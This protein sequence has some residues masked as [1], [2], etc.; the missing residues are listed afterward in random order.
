MRLTACL[1]TFNEERYIDICLDSIYPYV[2]EIIC[3]D[4]GSTDNTVNILKKYPKVRCYVVPQPSERRSYTGWNEGDR[5]NIT[6]DLARGEWILHIDSDE[7]LDDETWGHLD[8][9]FSDDAVVGYGFYR[10]NYFYNFDYH[11]PIDQPTDGGE[12]RI[13]RNSPEIKWG[14]NNNHNYLHF[15]GQRL[16]TYRPPIIKK[17]YHLIHHMHRINIRGH[18]AIHDR[19][20]VCPTVI[21]KDYVETKGF[22]MTADN[23]YVRPIK[24]PSILY[25]KG[26]VN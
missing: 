5:R 21:T 3:L 16:R 26:V 1:L 6:N 25:E 4:S 7:V 10:I 17:T 19:R 15:R 9:W 12:I 2:D 24:L 8:D 23:N 22:C 11:K 13:Y 20:D 14:T 18:K